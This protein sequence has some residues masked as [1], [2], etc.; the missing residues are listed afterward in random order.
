MGAYE[1]SWM[2]IPEVGGRMPQAVGRRQ[3]LKADPRPP[4][5]LGKRWLPSLN[6]SWIRAAI[7]GLDCGPLPFPT[8][9]HPA[10]GQDERRCIASGQGE[11]LQ[12]TQNSGEFTNVPLRPP[13]P[14]FAEDD[15]NPEWHLICPSDFAEDDK[16]PE[17]H[18]IC[19]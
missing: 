13:Y 6:T 18:L 10:G 16:N 8:S 1:E 17:W 4:R 9:R 3:F 11:P 5:M 19:P 2:N 7:I 15:K 12:V 14:D